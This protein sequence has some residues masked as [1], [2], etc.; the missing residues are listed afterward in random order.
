VLDNARGLDAIE[1]Q[2]E[3]HVE[4][5]IVKFEEV[6]AFKMESDGAVEEVGLDGDDLRVVETGPQRSFLS[7]GREIRPIGERRLLFG[8]VPP[9]RAGLRQSI[10]CM[11]RNRNALYNSVRPN[12]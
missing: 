6:I 3:L 2:E 11:P 12:W 1:A 10:A 9:L 7:A 8:H 4:R 5:E